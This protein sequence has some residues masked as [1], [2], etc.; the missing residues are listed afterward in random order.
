MLVQTDLTIKEREA[1]DE[2]MTAVYIEV[3]YVHHGI[4]EAERLLKYC[5]KYVFPYFYHNW[6]GPDLDKAI[7]NTQKKIKSKKKKGDSLIPQIPESEHDAI[8]QMTLGALIYNWLNQVPDIELGQEKWLRQFQE[9]RN[10]FN[11]SSFYEQYN[12]K[13]GNGVNDALSHIEV[14]NTHTRDLIN[15]L[16]VVMFRYDEKLSTPETK[17]ALKLKGKFYNDELYKYHMHRVK[18]GYG[19]K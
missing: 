15:I 6:K 13:T 9:L 3:G 17:L 11:H 19:L 14:L 2:K 7:L 12:F 1:L 4:A 16:R 10:H 18:E 5:W 8:D